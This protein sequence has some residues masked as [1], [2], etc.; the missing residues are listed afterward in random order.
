MKK[1]IVVVFGTLLFA[2]PAF[3]QNSQGADK[4]AFF[5]GAPGVIT[6]TEA[7]TARVGGGVETVWSNGL[8]FAFDAGYFT[9][10][11]FGNGAVSFS[12]AI[13]YEF[14]VNGRVRPYVRGGGA[15]LANRHGGVALWTVG[16]GVNYWFKER[17]A[18]KVEIRD[19]FASEDP[20]YGL[21]DVMIGL[22][23]RY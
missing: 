6:G 16:G 1:V 10:S 21:L 23:F 18:L 13:I 20:R 7:T 22:V 14:P 4:R 8:G 3:A 11:D 5:F 15:L 9:G 17:M 2:A 12:P 19:S